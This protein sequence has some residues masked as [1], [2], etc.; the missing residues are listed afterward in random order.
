MLL[1]RNLRVI[2]Y[3]TNIKTMADTQPVVSAFAAR[4]QAKL[5]QATGTAEVTVPKV[6]L[7]TGRPSVSDELLKGPSFVEAGKVSRL[8]RSGLS[9]KS[10]PVADDGFSDDSPYDCDPEG[11]ESNL[12]YIALLLSQT[13]RADDHS[14]KKSRGAE[15]APKILPFTTVKATKDAIIRED[16]G[17][18][19]IKLCPGDVC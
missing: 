4:Q 2:S 15:S 9:E 18:I 11:A 6:E 3:H 10:S 5:A 14:S 7:K 17:N 1:F 13:R 12:K 8:F 16:G 19:R